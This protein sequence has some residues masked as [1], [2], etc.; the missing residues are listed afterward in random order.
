MLGD[1]PGDTAERPVGLVVAAVVA[2]VAE[3]F[4]RQHHRYL[5]DTSPKHR[6]PQAMNTNYYAHHDSVRRGIGEAAGD[7]ANAVV[8]VEDEVAAAVVA[9]A[10]A[11]DVRSR[12][13]GLDARTDGDFGLAD[14][15]ERAQ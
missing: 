3:A 1:S 14:A 9:A 10:V 15:A 4:E 2:V 7:A 12:P 5:H 11:V 6:H 13:G 8:A